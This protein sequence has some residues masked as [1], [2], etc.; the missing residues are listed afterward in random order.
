ML[1]GIPFALFYSFLGIPIAALADRWN[2][3][4]VLA[5]SVALWSGM[6]A[7]CGMAVNFPMLFAARVGTAIG[8]AGG[9]SAVALAHLRLLS[10]ELALA[11]RSRSTRWPSPSAPRSA[12]HGRVGQPDLGWRNTFIVVGL[13]GLLLA[14]AVRLSVR[15]PPRGMADGL[16]GRAPPRRRARRLTRCCRICG[17]RVVPA[18]QPG[19]GAALGGVVFERRVQQRLPAALARAEL[20]RGGPVDCD[21]LA[22]RRYRHVPWRLCLRSL[23]TRFND[24]RW[25]L[26]VPGIAT[27]LCV[28]FQFL[29]Y[30]SPALNTTLTSFVGSCS[31]R[32]CS[33]GRRSP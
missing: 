5:L 16:S 7:L 22:H 23:S 27:L 3:V 18:P 31:W 33:S 21:P 28:P 24:R 17:T 10:Q 6:T 4:K 12:L 14:L 2:R 26:W 1:S 29:A 13:P 8:E 32:P 15:E 25:Y 19:R 9:Q 20:V 30:L 11:P